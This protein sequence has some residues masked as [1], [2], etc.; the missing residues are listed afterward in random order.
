[1]VSITFVP[2][3]PISGSTVN[4]PDVEFFFNLSDFEN[5]VGSI[6]FS[7]DGVTFFSVLQG[8]GS[9]G[10]CS[11]ADFPVSGGSFTLT[12]VH[13]FF[14][15]RFRVIDRLGNIGPITLHE[16][17]VDIFTNISIDPVPAI[18]NNPSL[19]ITGI[20]EAGAAVT[21]TNNGN[22]VTPVN[23]P[24]STT[25][26]ALVILEEGVNVILATGTDTE[27][28]QATATVTV[29]LD[30]IDPGIPVVT[31]VD[32]A[33][34]EFSPGLDPVDTNEVDQIII[35]EKEAGTAI[36]INGV[37]VVPLN[38]D[39]TFSVP[40]TLV[41]GSN[42]FLVKTR[43]E[44]SNDSPELSVALVL[45]T[46]APGSPSIVINDGT[47]F[48]L[49]RDVTLTLSATDATEVRVSED[50]NFTN[51]DFISF[52]E[53]PTLLPFELSRGGGTKTVFAVFRDSVGNETSP[54]FDTIILPSTESEI[55][56]SPDAM[57]IDELI[58]EPEAEYLIRLEDNR[59]GTFTVGLFLS[60]T[61]ALNETNRVGFVTSSNTGL[62]T[63]SLVPESGGI[64]PGGQI[65][66]TLIDG[67]EL[68][69]Y[70]FRTDVF[71]AS[72]GE[73]GVPIVYQIE[74]PTNP[75]FDAQVRVPIFE[76]CA[77][78]R[79]LE[80]FVDGEANK[81]RISKGFE[82]DDED[83][84]IVDTEYFEVLDQD[85]PSFPIASARFDYPLLATPA[86]VL[87]IDEEEDAFLIT[88]DEDLPRFDET[89]G[90]E[91]LFSKRE[92]LVTDYRIFTD[93]RVEFLNESNLASGNV[94]VTYST[95]QTINSIPSD[96]F[97]AIVTPIGSII[98]LEVEPT[99]NLILLSDLDKVCIRFFH[100][101]IDP[102][103]VAP[104]FI[105]VTING[106]TTAST[107]NFTIVASNARAEIREFCVDTS[108]LFPGGIDSDA[109]GAGNPILS[110]VEIS[111]TALADPTFSDELQVLAKAEIVSSNCRVLVNGQEVFFSP[112][113]V[114]R[115]FDSYELRV[116][117]GMVDVV[118]NNDCVHTASVD[119]DG[120]TA[121]F[122]AGA[123]VDGDQVRSTFSEFTTIQYLDMSPSAILLPGR[124]I[125]VEGVLRRD[126]GLAPILRSF[127]L[128][129]VSERVDFTDRVFAPDLLNVEFLDVSTVAIIGVGQREEILVVQGLGEED[130]GQPVDFVATN[131]PDGRHFQVT[132]FPIVAS[133]LRVR[134]RYNGQDL[135]LSENVDFHVD[136]TSGQ[137]SLFHPVALSDTLRVEYTSEADVNSPELFTDLNLLTA[138]HGAASLQ[139]T[140]SLGAQLAFENG[141][142]RVLAV[143]ALTPLLDPAWTLAYESLRKHEAYFVVPIP[144]DSYP[145]IVTAGLDHVISESST[146]HR[147]ERVLFA[148]QT[149][150]FT[151]D[152]I[153]PLRSTFRGTFVEPSE[154]TIILNG[155]TV[156][157]DGKF[158][159]AAYAGKFSFLNLIS[160]P[161]SGKSLTG[162][163]LTDQ[164]RLTRVQLENK[165][166]DGIVVL[167]PI[168]GGAR[169]TRSVTIV[170]SGL[171]VEE[172]QSVVRIRDYLAINIRE[173]LENRFVGRVVVDTIIDQ[174]R[175][176]AERF[177]AAQIARRIISAFQNVVARVD[178]EEPRQVNVSFDVQPLFPLNQLTVRINAVA[179]I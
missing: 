22:S 78:G 106:T 116:A 130:E 155:E 171:A 162:I 13:G 38:N 156:P 39:T 7:F 126:N 43:D 35:G 80:A 45:D 108:L 64:D 144:P 24:T 34:P 4:V 101:L 36:F 29:V 146:R 87:S 79:I 98:T 138:K 135:L 25:W 142:K 83:T 166:K 148:G 69:I 89:F 109:Y 10:S 82:L 102:L 41:E 70:R 20:R 153:I 147:H 150:D 167:Q 152:D 37:E 151:A 18:V 95:D 77:F 6:E 136:V 140:L 154:A 55:I 30:T 119:M 81:L 40:V 173:V 94:R 42:V 178:S 111:F 137:I 27:S 117:P 15:I 123:R 63:L 26:D 118:C 107:A 177:L 33:I 96:E 134:L 14:T 97:R 168:S 32:P 115:A 74:G 67:A 73:L 132:S 52:S 131:L 12:F 133:T 127:E 149:E 76:G 88:I 11:N 71:D 48:T 179:T 75:H 176:E 172:E 99:N 141:A 28:N 104:A 66:V 62:Q 174:V 19:P 100:S 93:G 17:N 60:L 103:I 47:D 49:I 120:A 163:S 8:L 110:N 44:A 53:D 165:I 85:G 159:A 128:D 59:D 105:E 86:S 122:G 92:S 54:V 21:V 160:E 157:I 72:A 50:P 124:F 46:I 161:A 84:A 164:T 16:L 158:L 113:E 23:L 61:D 129:F 1:M 139:N 112:E 65:T 175:V 5:G 2:P 114:T 58:V 31:E 91:M 90:Y 169:I 121:I 145:T 9:E 170:E 51:D 57:T 125:E 143:Q 56:S 68:I 3:T